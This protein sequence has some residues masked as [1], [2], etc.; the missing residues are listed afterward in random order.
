MHS[1]RVCNQP[2]QLH[3]AWG[4]ALL[5]APPY[6]TVQGERKLQPTWEWTW[7][8]CAWDSNPH[9]SC[10]WIMNSCFLFFC[11][12][13]AVSFWFCPIIEKGFFIVWL[14]CWRC[15][16]QICGPAFMFWIVCWTMRGFVMCDWYAYCDGD[17]VHVTIALSV[18]LLIL[19]KSLAVGSLLICVLVLEFFI[20]SG[21]IWLWESRSF[22]IFDNWKLRVYKW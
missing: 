11:Y 8:G 15:C 2:I 14:K 10:C 6:P 7:E 17:C 5:Q 18:F 3:C 12:A 16:H 22:N 21:T 9:R 4:K 1:W 13:A 19:N 20:F